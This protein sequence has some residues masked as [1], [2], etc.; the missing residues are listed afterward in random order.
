MMM[1]VCLNRWY[2]IVGVL[3]NLLYGGVYERE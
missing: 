2:A 3:I 1:N